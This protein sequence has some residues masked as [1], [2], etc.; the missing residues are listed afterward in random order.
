MV[1]WKGHI[2][3]TI[4]VLSLQ[5]LGTDF[6][7][8]TYHQYDGTIIHSSHCRSRVIA[9]W[10][11]PWYPRPHSHST[12]G[13]RP[14]IMGLRHRPMYQATIAGKQW[15][16]LVDPGHFLH[17]GIILLCP[18]LGTMIRSPRLGCW[19]GQLGLHGLG[20]SIAKLASS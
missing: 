2:F 16:F 20:N 7:S 18:N 15:P 8:H 12:I 6:S 11:V 10:W 3:S 9:V 17:A 19:Q 5:W 4:V 1:W 14:N 13:T